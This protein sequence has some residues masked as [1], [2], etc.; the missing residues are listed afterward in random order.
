MV[1]KVQTVFETNLP[2]VKLL[3][4]GKV[5]DIYDLGDEILVVA[6]DRISAFDSV[7]ATPIRTTELLAGK[8]LAALVPGVLA[9]WSTYLL[10]ITLAS[11]LYGPNLFGVVTDASWPSGT[12][13]LGPAIGLAS[14]LARGNPHKAQARTPYEGRNPRELDELPRHGMPLSGRQARRAGGGAGPARG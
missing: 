4:R 11:L 13:A 5:R 6:T 9:G 12:L 1:T 7:L 10:F 3:T 2:D 8:V 14:T